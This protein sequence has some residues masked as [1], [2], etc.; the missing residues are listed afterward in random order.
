VIKFPPFRYIGGMNGFEKLL[1]EAA[2]IEEKIGY[3][4]KDKNLLATAFV[5]RSFFN[6]NREAIAHHN[7][8]LE[9]LGDSVL[10]LIV[11]DYLYAALPDQPEGELSHL[12]SQIVEASSCADYAQQLGI[13]E[14][15]LLGRGERMNDGKGR[16]TILADLLEAIIG[17]IYLDGGLEEARRVFLGHFQEAMLSKLKE[18][19]RNWKAELQDYSQKKHQKPPIYKV[20][21]ESGPDHSKIFQIVVIID[22]KEVGEGSGSSKKQA[23]QAAAETALKQLEKP[24]G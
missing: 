8:R 5:H 10:G 12:R 1:Q 21:G 2:L 23:E 18:P 22:D 6:E 3:C 16:E 4:F 7:E 19:L 17:A 15:V 20:V 11:S 14:F 24:R 13:A 9:F